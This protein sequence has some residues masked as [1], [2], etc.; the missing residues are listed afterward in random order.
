MANYREWDWAAI[1]SAYCRVREKPMAE[2]VAKPVIEELQKLNFYGWDVIC[3]VVDGTLELGKY[4]LS[5]KLWIVV[6][7]AVKD[8]ISEIKG[9]KVNTFYVP[10]FQQAGY[11]LPTLTK[12]I[13]NEIDLWINAVP[14][15]KYKGLEVVKRS[16]YY[17]P[18]RFDLEQWAQC[19]MPELDS[20]LKDEYFKIFH[21]SVTKEELAKQ[22]GIL[23][24]ELSCFL[25]RLKAL[26][27]AQTKVR[28]NEALAKIKEQ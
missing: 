28:N 23:Q 5:D 2:E 17:S 20:I 18:E 3:Q 14:S 12:E 27:T 13:D 10:K 24:H 15:F 1:I 4:V 9:D 21:E 8:K 22:D 26:R 19:G 11:T 25:G 6:R 16:K 7:D